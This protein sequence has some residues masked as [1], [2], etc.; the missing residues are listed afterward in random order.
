M[1]CS[2]CQY[3]NPGEAAFCMKCGT[4]LA[5][6]EVNATS[7][8]QKTSEAE[9]RQLTVIFCDLV[10]ST[11]LSEQ[12]DAEDLREVIRS[13]QD[14]CA[15]AVSR[16]EGYIA[17]YIG[18]GVL[19]Y[20]GY[21]I[22]HEDDA[23]RAIHCGLAIVDQVKRL[24]K[25]L[26]KEKG[27]DLKVR[28]G[29]H[30]GPV[31]AGEMGSG[32]TREE[33]AIV[34]K[35]PNIGARIEGIAEANSV[36]M[37]SDTYRL[38][39]DDFVCRSMGFHTLKGI[40]EPMEV[41]QALHET[42]VQDRLDKT[43]SVKERVPLVGRDQE[44]QEILKRWEHIE[45]GLGQL[46]LLKGEP[47]LGKSR[48]VKEFREQIVNQAH[49][50]QECRCSP[51]H[52]NSVLYPLVNLL[53]KILQLH[54]E[55]PPASK[56]DKLEEFLSEYELPL[57]EA[58]PLIADLCSLSLE[59]RY[60]PLQTTP[61]KIR[62]KTLEVLANLLVEMAKRRPMLFIIEDLHWSDPTT[63]EFLNL[64]INRLSTVP[65]LA[66]LTFRPVFLPPWPLENFTTSIQ[67]SSLSLEVIKPI[68]D[69]LAG[70]KSLP[71]EVLQQ[72]I[73]KTDGVPLF[74][75]ELTKM[76][77]ES[78]LLEEQ[79]N[80][81]E[82]TAPLP[83]LAIPA[84]I[85]GSLMARLDRL[86]SAKEIAQLGAVLGREFSYSWIQKLSS[87]EETALQHELQKLVDAELLDQEDVP[88][89]ANYMFRH[90]LVQDTAYQSL[91]KSKRAQVHREIANL[92]E[93]KF[94]EI[95][96]NQPEFIAYHYSEGNMIEQAVKFWENAGK[97]ALQR[98]AIAEAINH[99]N[100]GLRL[101][102]MLPET[103]EQMRQ[104]IEL[105]MTL[106]MAM[107]LTPD[108]V[109]PKVGAVYTRTRELSEQLE[110]PRWLFRVLCG[111]ANLYNTPKGELREICKYGERCMEAAEKLNDTA[112]RIEAHHML[113][114]AKLHLGDCLGADIHA[115][116]IKACYNPDLHHEL[117]Y[118]YSGHDP[119]V[120]SNTC[121]AW[122]KWELGYPDQALQRA[123]YAVSLADQVGHPMSHG[124]AKHYITLIHYLRGEF[125]QAE[126]RAQIQIAYCEEHG[127]FL[128]ELLGRILLGAT[129]VAQ[130]KDISQGIEMSQNGL[131]FFQ[132]SGFNIMLPFFFSLA[133]EAYRDAGQIE[134]GL[135]TLE[136]GLAFAQN[137]EE[138]LH[139]PELFRLK[140]ELLLMQSDT[141]ENQQLA[142]SLFKL[143][144][145][146]AS[147]QQTKS[148]ELRAVTHLAQLWKN[149]GRS[150]EA[151]QRLA[152]IYHWFTEGETTADV[153]AAK[154]L[155]QEFS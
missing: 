120:C 10:G 64:L 101:V 119:G 145:E 140:G 26:Q 27:I 17:K 2:N 74:V 7:K 42:G 91:L 4:R 96:Q 12:L 45:N 126:E 82:L 54:P 112:L 3:E 123:Q 29:V 155:L 110:D 58:V 79:E 80:S 81:Y 50:E 72:L 51:Y 129:M 103:P 16:F 136:E 61:Q 75:E 128:W 44:L 108:M 98:S 89:Q 49:T 32:D 38:I 147:Q 39:K 114:T 68:I 149:Q 115:S 109:S 102:K 87:L 84:T 34:G 121:S 122:I 132:T 85:Q 55:D 1:Q 20:F 37:S 8:L 31:I 130:G 106:A 66:L 133:A 28:L 30:T 47:G 59:E 152:P 36:V 137:S 99:L 97:L 21:P 13:Y 141:E 143:A 117:T 131:D 5:E 53:V 33:H 125:R 70:G 73:A 22:A 65:I 135:K 148:L 88:P 142:E 14:V 24:A 18:D 151:Y 116:A 154:T 107:S 90:A 43:A 118:L 40:S 76:V 56:L 124:F 6:S 100:E 144:L 60:S 95:T 41:Y 153:K 111:Q 93:T 69:G 139:V 15:S 138:Q 146:R 19:I 67:L 57:S 113:W 46:V 78:G 52:H 62:E 9:H 48:L 77:L 23:Q 35:T 86:D 71:D 25:R 92:L 150:K 127:I 63:Q 83:T 104:E 94:P 105:Q 134:Q 11:A